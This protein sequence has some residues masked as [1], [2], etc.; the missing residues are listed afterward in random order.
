MVKR[1]NAHRKIA[2]LLLI[3][4][5]VFLGHNLVPH[6]HIS[7]DLFLPLAAS[8]PIDHQ[9]GSETTK[10]QHPTHCHAFND[11]AFENFNYTIYNPQHS[12]IQDMVEPE[13]VGDHDI[14]SLLPGSRFTFLDLACSTRADKGS[15]ALRA[16]PSFG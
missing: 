6:H 9:Y 15:H 13:Q 1:M 12:Q 5:S 14:L 3:C 10:D 2:I 7:E 11:V 16:P 8:C 4:F